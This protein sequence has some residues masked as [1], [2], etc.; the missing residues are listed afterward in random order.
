MYFYEL[1]S[2]GIQQLGVEADGDLPNL[3]N[4]QDHSQTPAVDNIGVGTTQTISNQDFRSH[5]GLCSTVGFHDALLAHEFGHAKVCYLQNRNK[6]WMW[7]GAYGK[8]T[9]LCYGK[10]SYLDQGFGIFWR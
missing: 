2:G 10:W 7:I 6:F 1:G 3:P 9:Q 5:V 8:H 4:K